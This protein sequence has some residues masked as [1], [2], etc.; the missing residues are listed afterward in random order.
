[1]RFQIALLIY[2]L[3][4][5]LLFIT[6]FPGW[7]V[8]MIRRGGIG[9]RLGERASIYT[10]ELGH[11]PCGQIHIHSIS[12]GE[13][14]LALK[15]IREWRTTEPD[16]PFVI[17][18]GTATGHAVA[19]S[20][21][22]KNIRVTYSPL[23][24]PCMVR[25]YLNRFEPAKLVL[26]EGEAWPHLLRLCNQRDIPVSLINARLSPRSARRYRKFSKWISPLFGMLDALAI[27]ESS[28]QPVW[29]SL[30]VSTE[31]IHVTGSLKFDPGTG[32]A[33]TR[34]PEFQQML[35]AFGQNRKVI[36]AASTHTGEEA[37]LASAMRDVAD[38]SL[39]VIVPRHAERRTEV[40]QALRTL[41]F[42]PI[43]RSKFTPPADPATAC[44]VV[45]STGELRDWTAH[46]DMVII[47]KS[48]LAEGGQNPAEAILAHKPLIFGPHMENFQPLASRLVETNAAICVN[49]QAELTAA[50][51]RV[52]EPSS[53]QQLTDH[54]SQL[55]NQHEGAT[56]RMISLISDE[57]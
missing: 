3:A 25:R 6:A 52:L 44:L 23:D 5:P 38:N 37:W 49:S 10:S 11:E 41:G 27:Q 22:L 9:T 31:K 24:F 2:R 26:I 35:N 46:A 40:V 14:M 32:S 47:G 36:L 54:A 34:R 57:T 33:P 7:V 16:R 19:T 39:P 1:M 43:L 28:D 48:F 55:L 56:R 13:T 21:G 29:E 42:D 30:G 4:L 51:R 50:I 8:K 12:V 45:D 20:S 15:L 53:A 18:V 17:A